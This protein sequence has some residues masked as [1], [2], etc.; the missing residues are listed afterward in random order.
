MNSFP[1]QD[2]KTVTDAERNSTSSESVDTKSHQR[3][4]LSLELPE[5]EAIISD[6]N[7]Q[8]DFTVNLN[9]AGAFQ[10]GFDSNLDRTAISTDDLILADWIA[11]TKQKQLSLK[12]EQSESLEQWNSRY[13]DWQPLKQPSAT[14][15]LP[16]ERLGTFQQL[17]KSLERWKRSQEFANYQL[18]RRKLMDTFADSL[19][20]V[21]RIYNR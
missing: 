9:E 2:E 17:Q 11:N 15:C 8:G 21:H 14:S 19:L 4:L 18:P 12:S 7:N 16:W 3:K 1:F 10:D 5:T 20:H 13:G 6:L